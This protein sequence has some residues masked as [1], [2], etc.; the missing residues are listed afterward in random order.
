MYKI[1]AKPATSSLKSHILPVFK[2]WSLSIKSFQSSS[3]GVSSLKSED[4]VSSRRSKSEVGGMEFQVG[5]PSSKT[6][7]LG[8][9]SSLL[10][11]WLPAPQD[12]QKSI[13]K[14]TKISI[15][16]SMKFFMD[17][18]SHLASKLEQKSFQNHKNYVLRAP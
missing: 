12:D 5:G 18:W 17:F 2:Y 3:S 15:K 4:Q 14:K 6:K 16:C 11:A 10:V 7:I 8:P 9:P 1:L 13:Q